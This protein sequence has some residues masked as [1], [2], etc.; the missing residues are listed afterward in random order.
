MSDEPPSF[1]AQFVS[2]CV[3][4][5]STLL[6]GLVFVVCVCMPALKFWCDYDVREHLGFEFDDRTMT[7]RSTNSPRSINSS[8]CSH[9]ESVFVKKKYRKPEL[10]PSS[11]NTNKDAIEDRLPSLLPETQYA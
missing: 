4:C 1:G 10:I 2:L 6:S 9:S 8:I 11:R 5:A 7:S 3:L